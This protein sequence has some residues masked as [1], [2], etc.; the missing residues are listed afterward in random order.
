[1]QMRGNTKTFKDIKISPKIKVDIIHVKYL[2]F[3]RNYFNSFF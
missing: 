3:L 1:M 2:L